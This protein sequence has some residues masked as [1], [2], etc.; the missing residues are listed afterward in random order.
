MSNNLSNGNT[1]N[2]SEI[3]SFNSN[4]NPSGGPPPPPKQK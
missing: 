4:A 3:S 2:N 1:S